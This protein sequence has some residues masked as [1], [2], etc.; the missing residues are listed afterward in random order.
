MQLYERAK[1]FL[2]LLSLTTMVVGLISPQVGVGAASCRED[3]SGSSQT[4]VSSLSVNEGAV[5]TS[6]QPANPTHLDSTPGDPISQVKAVLAA[7]GQDATKLPWVGD[8]LADLLGSMKLED[9]WLVGLTLIL[10]VAWLIR[11]LI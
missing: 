10:L 2:M 9:H 8:K 6:N 11:R 3:N 7:V 5:C 4:G 1:R